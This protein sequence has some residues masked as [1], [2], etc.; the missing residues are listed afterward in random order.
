M[1]AGNSYSQM[2]RVVMKVIY[3]EMGGDPGNMIAHETVKNI[4][5]LAL[6]VTREEIQKVIERLG[7][8]KT[9]TVTLDSVALTP[10]SMS[11]VEDNA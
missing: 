9:A 10:E 6:G 7:G 1:S 5:S 2:R 8:E 4:A 3:D 11:E